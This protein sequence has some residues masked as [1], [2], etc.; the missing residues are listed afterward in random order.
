MEK[1]RGRLISQPWLVE[2]FT[3]LGAI[4]YIVQTWRYSFTQDTILDEGAYLLKGYLFATG[5]YTIFQDNGVWSNHMPLAF[6]I[7]GVIQ[8]IFGPGLRTARYFAVFISILILLGLWL[9]TRRERG[10]WWAL[11]QCGL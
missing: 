1:I 7:P 2:M 10:R 9:V 4:L 3:L 5:Q 8:V 11:E 6:L